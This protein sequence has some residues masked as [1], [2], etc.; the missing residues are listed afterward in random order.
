VTQRLPTIR[1]EQFHHLPADEYELIEHW[2]EP[3]GRS[4]QLVAIRTAVR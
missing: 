2:L 3:S 4:D 1:D